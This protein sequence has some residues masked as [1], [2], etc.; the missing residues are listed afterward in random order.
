MEKLCGG[1]C[2]WSFGSTRSKGVGIWFRDGLNYKILKESRD[3]E[4]RLLS[5]NVQFNEQRYILTNIYAP[6]TAKERKAFFSS[7]AYYLKGN[8]P[9]I[10][11]GDFNCVVNNNLDKRGGSDVYGEFGSENLKS[12]CSDFK[13]VDTFRTKF[14]NK[15]E[16]T[17][18]N[19]LGNVHVRL[20]RIYVSKSITKDVSNVNHLP[21]PHKVSDHDMVQLVLKTNA[22][23]H[24]E[25]GP[26]FWKCNVNVLKDTYFQTDFIRL[27]EKFEKIDDQH[28]QWWE[29]CKVSLNKLIIS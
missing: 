8:H 3:C 12:I 18:V 26:G 16:Y 24:K 10:L 22:T 29:E 23:G 15:K 9:L 5:L 28:L 6:I 14:G 4:G 11:G 19:S 13:L 27:W 17:W 1:K 20:D 2:F 25:M 21:I 7:F